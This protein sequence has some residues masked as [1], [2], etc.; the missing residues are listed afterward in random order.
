MANMVLAWNQNDFE[1]FR[2]KV[3]DFGGFA[4]D[5]DEEYSAFMAKAAKMEADTADV[6]QMLKEAYGD[7]DDSNF[8]GRGTPMR[9]GLLQAVSAAA[10]MGVYTQ[11]IKLIE[12]E[13]AKRGIVLEEEDE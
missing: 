4:V 7:E 11:C 2:T 10:K 5:T 3:K 6:R 13:C 8:M 1:G 9:E 12:G